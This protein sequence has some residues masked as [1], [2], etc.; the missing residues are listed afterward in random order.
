MPP[1]RRSA[2]PRSLQSAVVEPLLQ[3]PALSAVSA[4]ALGNLGAVSAQAGLLRR[5]SKEAPMSEPAWAA[6]ALLQLSHPKGT[7]VLHSLLQS[8]DHLTQI[9]AALRLL[10][11]GDLEAPAA[12]PADCKQH[13]RP[14]AHA[15][16]ADHAGP[17]GGRGGAPQ[18]G[19][20]LANSPSLANDPLL[21]Y[22][23]A[24]LGDES[25][26]QRLRASTGAGAQ[27]VLATRLDLARRVS[28]KRRSSSS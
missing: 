8:A 12:A 21:L 24:K 9:E 13:R 7:A 22:S 25:R 16:G 1:S 2:E 14:R 27:A 6:T 4:R 17:P 19:K 5:W 20:G 23:L 28:R 10:E 11:H 18:A 26:R 15:A 3:E